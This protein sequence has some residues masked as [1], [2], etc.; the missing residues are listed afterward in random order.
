MAAL[1]GGTET[2]QSGFIILSGIM[3]HSVDTAAWGSMRQE[4]YIPLTPSMRFANGAIA[5]AMAPRT[6]VPAEQFPPAEASHISGLPCSLS[7]FLMLISAVGLVRD[8]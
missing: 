6:M 8:A 2:G 3:T 5:I 7:C 1:E 4:S